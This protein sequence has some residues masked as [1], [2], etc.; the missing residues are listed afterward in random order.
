MHHLIK[1]LIEYK[2]SHKD[3]FEI[4]HEGTRDNQSIN[5]LKCK[6]SGVLVLDKINTSK[7]F[8]ETDEHYNQ[9][10]DK[11]RLDDDERRYNQYKLLTQNKKVLDFGCGKGEFIKK[12]NLTTKKVCGVE[13]HNKNRK[14][15]IKNKF[16]VKK[17]IND[18]GDET[19]DFVFLNHVFEHL[20][21]PAKELKDIKKYL[22]KDSQLI[23]EIPHANDFLIQK[24]ENNDFKKF[25]FWSEHLILHTKESLQKFLENSGYKTVEILGFQRYPLS[26]HFHWMNERKPGGQDIYNFLNSTKVS[27]TYED[28]LVENDWTDT[29]IGVFCI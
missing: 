6:K 29:L 20:N 18:F 14:N 28:F 7:E 21:D 23:I 5:V 2:I 15:L 12:I 22:H 27:D 24:I 1:N 16:D 26:N 4:F 13:L 17:N 3:S 25:T 9:I 11:S 8:Y 19:F 10:S